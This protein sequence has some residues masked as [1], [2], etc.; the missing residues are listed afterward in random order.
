MV[1][2][3]EMKKI[4]FKNAQK[5][6]ASFI[7]F[8]KQSCFLFCLFLFPFFYVLHAYNEY[9]GLI[10]FSTTGNLLVA[11]FLLTAVLILISLLFLPERK[12]FLF[13]FSLL[14]AY[15]FF[16]AIHDFIK[17]LSV[18]SFLY[19]YSFLLPA[20]F[21]LF[22]FLYLYLRQSKRAFKKSVRV[23]IFFMTISVVIDIGLFVYYIVSH[24]EKDN[25]LLASDRISLNESTVPPL[26]SL[27]DIY[28]II[29]DSYTNSTILKEAIGFDNKTLDSIFKKNGFFVT[30][31]SNS[32]YNVT[33][34][35]LSSSLDLNYLKQ[36]IEDKYLSS[37][38]MLQSVYSLE[39]VILPDFLK[40][41]GYECINIGYFDINHFPV[42][43]VAFFDLMKKNCISWQTLSGR[44]QRDIG[45]YFAT[46]NLL[47][48][49]FRIPDYYYKAKSYHLD[50][51]HN[52]Y[53]SLVNLLGQESNK[54]PKFVYTHLML[55]HEPFYLDSS[56]R[57]ISDT[58]IVKGSVDPFAGYVNQV[59]YVNIL[60]QRISELVNEYTG[61]K[62]V[63]IIQGDHGLRFF[64]GDSRYQEFGCLNS[65]FFSDGNY[66]SLYEGISPVNSFRVVLNNYFGQEL[67]LLNDKSVYINKGIKVRLDK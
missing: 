34:F 54:S 44:F 24:K 49:D 63:V 37:L 12:T 3:S 29:S 56:G 39:N 25:L 38:S 27:P 59:K 53:D 58:L 21:L 57:S 41:I 66:S 11:Y 67:P 26:D 5:R 19:S 31:T 14:Y 16:G 62:K 36:G 60:L 42:E 50:V 6:L 9:F 33:P 40:K 46:R 51:T 13:V 52:N 61:R 28:Y 64:K 30:T 18:P 55:P 15:F 10:P 32:N 48:G 22:V 1:K 43:G 17:E 4:W 65:Y 35:S 20:I 7:V 8:K 45:W 47:T 2:G 23:I